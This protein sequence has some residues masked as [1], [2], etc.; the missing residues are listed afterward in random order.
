[1]P[2]NASSEWD[3][4]WEHHEAIVRIYV[5]PQFREWN[6]L[7]NTLSKKKK[8]FQK[9]CDISSGHC[10]S[11]FLFMCLNAGKLSEKDGH[12]FRKAICPAGF[13]FRFE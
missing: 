9:T 12:D 6:W 3:V 5:N 2:H 8:G 1:M 11:W 7:L 13:R 10:R 4:I